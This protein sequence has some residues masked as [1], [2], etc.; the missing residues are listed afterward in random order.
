MSD[1]ARRWTIRLAVSATLGILLLLGWTQRARFAPADAG[2]VT[3]VYVA[4]S[5][6]GDTISL[7]DYRGPVVLLNVWATWCRPC[8]QEM[9]A[10]ERLHNA[11]VAEGLAILAVSVDAPA[12]GLDDPNESVR[13]FAE[14]LGLTTSN[15]PVTKLV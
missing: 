10:L 5:L 11:L 1:K 6:D 8:V 13:A 2:T 3:P 15:S 14:Q 12:L 9:P 7:A 4:T